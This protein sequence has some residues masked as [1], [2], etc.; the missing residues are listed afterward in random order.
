MEK[1]DA[2]SLILGILLSIAVAGLYFAVF[3]FLQGKTIET[4]STSLVSLL[5]FAG[6]G[7][8]FWVFFVRG[9]TKKG[10]ELTQKALAKNKEEKE[11]KT[12]ELQEE[13]EQEKLKREFQGRVIAKTDTDK[14][15]VCVSL[16]ACE[17]KK[18][19]A[20]EPNVIE[21]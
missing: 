10:F 20:D 5:T 7:I 15:E 2:R 1:I 17:V 16:S 6:T 4:N 11:N 8:Y 12:L 19:L 14:E 3:Y 21:G 18:R 9:K 13:T